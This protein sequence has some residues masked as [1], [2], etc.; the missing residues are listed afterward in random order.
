MKYT[1][2][3]QKE[4]EQLY[5]LLQEGV[6]KTQI[7]KKMKRGRST[8][9][10]EIKRNSTV[11]DARYNNSPKKQKKHYLPDRAQQKYEKK[12]KESKHSFPL[13]SPWV[14]EYVIRKLKEGL[15]PEIISGRLKVKYEEQISPECIYQYIYSK[16]AKK[17]ELW[18]YLRRAHKKRRKQKGRKSRSEKIINRRDISLRPSVVEMRVRAGDW[19]GDSIVGRG[20]GSALHT[21]ANRMSRMVR[22][23][24]MKRKTAAEAAQAMISIFKALPE[25]LA[26]TSTLDNGPE[27]SKHEYVTSETGVDIY[28]ARPY[29]SWQRG[30]NENTNGLIRWYFPK[31]TNFD[32][33]SD[34]EIQHVEDALNNRPRK[35]LGYQT[36]LEV[37]NHILSTISQPVSLEN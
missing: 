36:P 4:R 20:K 1:H 5:A 34:E 6:P 10:N 19:E 7:A 21:Q 27:H 29:A 24:K 23:R 2:L 18:K 22:I 12:R 37:H 33:I 9:Q 28:F 26:M 16:R 14:H 30:T 15:S 25:Q 17:L 35:C 13:K 3:S 31:K 11:I 32:A 8:I